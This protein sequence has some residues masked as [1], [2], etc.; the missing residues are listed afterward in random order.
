MGEMENG[1][2][3]DGGDDVVCGK[4]WADGAGTKWV[5]G[6]GSGWARK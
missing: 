5:D 4:R 3:D 6:A 2:A 1:I